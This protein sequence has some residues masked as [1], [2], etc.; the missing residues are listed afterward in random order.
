MSVYRDL[1][2]ALMEVVISDEGNY[3]ITVL[4]DNQEIQELLVTMDVQDLLEEIRTA[5]NKEE[6]EE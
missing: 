4:D 5:L 3:R 2:E 6:D 1:L